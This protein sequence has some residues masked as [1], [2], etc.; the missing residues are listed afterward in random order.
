MAPSGLMNEGRSLTPPP[1]PQP[2]CVLHTPTGPQDSHTQ[3]RPTGPRVACEVS[4][5]CP[6]IPTLLATPSGS[7]SS[8]FSCHSGKSPLCSNQDPILSL[9]CSL[10]TFVP[11]KSLTS[12]PFPGSFLETLPAAMSITLRAANKNVGVTT[13]LSGR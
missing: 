1:C 12:V 7:Q 9:T 8:L 10:L 6:D 4:S 13:T 3:T 5:L 11:L 2:R